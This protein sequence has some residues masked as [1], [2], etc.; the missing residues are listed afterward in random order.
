MRKR[1]GLPGNRWCCGQPNMTDLVQWLFCSVCSLSQEVRT[2]NFYE[3]C[4]EKL[5][6]RQYLGQDSQDPRDT[7]PR[8]VR[9]EP[10]SPA[11]LSPA[12]NSPS[13]VK[14]G[15]S[16][17]NAQASVSP[18]LSPMH[19]SVANSL[20]PQG[21]SLLREGSTF[22]LSNFLTE[23]THIAIST[24][25]ESVDAHKVAAQTENSKMD[26]DPMNA[27]VPLNLER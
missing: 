18:V 11:V 25:S 6:S 19:Y 21:W 15:M 27:P 8:L 26:G 17:L 22:P 9:H 7:S 5:Y 24:E 4:D 13:R 20:P 2:G 16:A 23:E 12:V 3:V 1:F 14:S 10:G